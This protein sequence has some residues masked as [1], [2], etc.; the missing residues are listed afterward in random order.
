VNE[1]E[2]CDRRRESKQGGYWKGG[3]YDSEGSERLR[4]KT[5]MGLSIPQPFWIILGLGLLGLEEFR[6]NG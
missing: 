4:A 6:T 5:F 3:G 1:G 2:V